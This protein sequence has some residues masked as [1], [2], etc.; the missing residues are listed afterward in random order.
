MSSQAIQLPVSKS[1][2]QIHNPLIPLNSFS[3]G[4]LDGLDAHVVLLS[5][6]KK[7]QIQTWLP[8]MQLPNSL[9]INCGLHVGTIR[10]IDLRL[11]VLARS[12]DLGVYLP[13]LSS[14]HDNI[15][16]DPLPLG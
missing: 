13:K 10:S 9:R 12:Q 7:S 8:P 4:H 11:H 1:K 6:D 16:F 14:G 3:A 15:T 2:T 5:V